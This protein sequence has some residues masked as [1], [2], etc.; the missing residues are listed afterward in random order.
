MY[1]AYD[2]HQPGLAE[3]IRE[4][5]VLSAQQEPPL[6][7]YIMLDGTFD[8]DWAVQLYADS[9]QKN[10]QIQQLFEG[11]VQAS[12]EECAP[13]LCH[14]DVEEL[15]ALLVRTN[16]K[17]MFNLILSKASLPELRKHLLRFTRA[18]DQ[19]YLYFPLRL[20]DTVALPHI[21][22]VLTPAQQKL[23]FTGFSAWY[24]VNRAGA[25]EQL[26]PTHSQEALQ[27]A[28]QADPQVDSDS[29]VMSEEAFAYLM[30][31]SEPDQFLCRVGNS[32]PE[33]IE[34]RSA[35]ELYQMSCFIVSQI[36]KLGITSATDQA[37]A[38][39]TALDSR[40]EQEAVQQLKG[41]VASQQNEGAAA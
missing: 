2:P 1:Y 15:D 18:Q 9:Q 14:L 19:D 26:Q 6:Q 38:Y 36:H 21:V 7:A 8:Q 34:G 28:S 29:F 35:T 25:L 40:T 4:L 31:A 20:A 32:A 23:L 13:F 12:L 39:L 10:D 41:F 30:D 24:I 22:R 37:V 16:E 17:P 3:Q 27:A 33:Q 11:S 5:L